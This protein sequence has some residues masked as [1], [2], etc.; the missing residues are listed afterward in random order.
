MNAAAFPLL[1]AFAFAVALAASLTSVSTRADERA[2]KRPVENVFR[3]AGCF[4]GRSGRE[5]GRPF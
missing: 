3:F 4:A 1:A 5:V 2:W